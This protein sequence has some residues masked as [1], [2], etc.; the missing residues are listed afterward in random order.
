M[1]RIVGILVESGVTAVKVTGGEPLVRRDVDVLVRS[2]RAISDELDISMTTN[3]FLLGGMAPRLKEAGLDRVSVSCDSLIRHRFHDLTLRDALEEVMTGL[4]AAADAGLDPIKINTVL[5][6][7]RNEDEGVAFAQMARDTGYEVRFIE[8]MPLD[9]QDEWDGSAVVPGAEVLAAIGEV[10]PLISGEKNG[11]PAH[12]YRFAD[13]APGSI[14]LISAVTEPFC[15]SC[16]RLRLTA[17]GQL[18]ACLFSLEETDLR[19]PLRDG[20][21]DDELAALARECIAAKWAGHRVGQP[22]FVKPARS[23]SMIGG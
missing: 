7:G 20:A 18:R 22:D 3:G 6:R 12:S 23:M 2:V 1:A 17:D 19:G 4:R 14:G 13:G 9:A 10:F 8:Y 15:D 5:I 11:E 21:S 16:N